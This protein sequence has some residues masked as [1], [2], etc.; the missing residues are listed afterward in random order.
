LR[1]RKKIV[2]IS[3]PPLRRRYWLAAGK[4]E[5]KGAAYEEGD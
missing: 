2:L 3:K 4:P 1:T 5:A